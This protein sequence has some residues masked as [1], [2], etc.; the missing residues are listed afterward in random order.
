MKA[1]FLLFAL[2]W[3]MLTHVNGQSS[4]ANAIVK[5][6]ENGNAKEL[7]S[8]FLNTIDLTLIEQDDVYNKTQAEAMLIQFF[9]R[10]VPESIKVEHTGTSRQNDYYKIASLSTANG[11]YRVTFLL[12]KD[13]TDFKIKQLRIEPLNL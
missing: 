6:I 5:S 13:G 7:A 2:C 10:N 1:K 8:Y 4:E 12:K 9:R 3:L 11:Q